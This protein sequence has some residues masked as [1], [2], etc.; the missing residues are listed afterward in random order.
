MKD[1]NKSNKSAIKKHTDAEHSDEK[2]KVKFD[3]V[4][5]GGT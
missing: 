1:S 5:T 4:V 2:D 3:M